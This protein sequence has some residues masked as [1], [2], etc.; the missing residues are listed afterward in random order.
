MSAL[1][2]IF[3]IVLGASRNSGGLQSSGEWAISYKEVTH[4]SARP[5]VMR[6]LE[7]K[8]GGMTRAAVVDAGL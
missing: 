2:G 3:C 5:K 4:W 1:F 7:S 6:C 8:D